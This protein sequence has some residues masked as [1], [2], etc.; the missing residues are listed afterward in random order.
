MREAIERAYLN[1]QRR[2]AELDDFVSRSQGSQPSR[3]GANLAGIFKRRQLDKELAGL[4]PQM[5]EFR[6][7]DQSAMAKAIA[8]ATGTNEDLL[9]R[10][11]AEDLQK[12][13][14]EFISQRMKPQERKIIKDVGGF[15]RFQDT[16][17][18]VFP[19]AVPTKKDPLVNVNVGGT[20]EGAFA[21][22]FGENRA[23]AVSE[24]ID[25]ETNKTTQLQQ[26]MQA[27][28]TIENLLNQGIETGGFANVKIGLGNAVRFLGGDPTEF[29]ALKDIN[30]LETI[31]GM[32]NKLVIPM[33][34][35]LGYNPTDADAKRI[36][37]SVAGLGK[38]VE[39]N[40]ALIGFIRNTASK[41]QEVQELINQ[42]ELTGDVQKARNL[43]PTVNKLRKSIFEEELAKLEQAT[44]LKE[45]QENT[46]DTLPQD[47][48]QI[49]TSGGKPVYET[50]DGKRFIQ[51]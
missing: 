22:K 29:P 47:A 18:R 51:E 43:R 11:P 13:T 34:K 50:P 17:G 16:G 10:L 20:E 49:G 21:K 37:S 3:I 6:R 31:E 28:N 44:L 48:K 14:G 46:I 40:R 8:Q 35:Q 33:A 45:T 9:S 32:T 38:G 12:I 5:D 23:K 41:Q 30:S 2:R 42:V 26:S 24:F 7:Q 19:D 4:Q 39:A 27:V 25:T 36:E 15:Q 1:N